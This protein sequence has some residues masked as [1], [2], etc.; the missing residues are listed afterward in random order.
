MR[1]EPNVLNAADDPVALAKIETIVGLFRGAL[2][3]MLNEEPHNLPMNQ[4]LVMTASALMAGLTVG[5][6][7]AVGVL[8]EGD[9]ARARKVVTVAYNN[10]VK[11]GLREAR[12][13]MLEQMPTEGSS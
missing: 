1:G 12:D 10:G 6:M 13:A 2:V 3:P 9:K 7:I 8:K 11:A 5:H 4:S